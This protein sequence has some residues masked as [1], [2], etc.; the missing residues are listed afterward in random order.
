MLRGHVSVALMPRSCI[1]KV[2]LFK[3]PDDFFWFSLVF[4]YKWWYVEISQ[5]FFRWNSAVKQ[6]NMRLS[7][8]SR[9]Q[10]LSDAPGR[11]PQFGIDTNPQ[12][13]ET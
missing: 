4:P 6:P 5:D 10:I 1:L 12:R 11:G 2:P 9:S 8:D 13:L 7:V 3:C